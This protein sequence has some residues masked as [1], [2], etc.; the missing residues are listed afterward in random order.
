MSMWRKGIA[1]EC[2]YLGNPLI[3]RLIGNAGWLLADRIGRLGLGVV[4]LAW[5]AR[6]LG[7]ANFGLLNYAQA[8]VVLVT[9]VAQFGLAD[10]VVRDIV[11]HP[12]RRDAI[13]STALFIRLAMGA[14]SVGLSCLTVYLLDP[15]DHRSL[16]IT[17]ALSISLL[18]QA[19]EVLEYD[20]QA[21]NHV[22]PAVAARSAAFFI[23]N[24]IKIYGILS[25][26][27]LV[28][29]AVMITAEAAATAFFFGFANRE[30]RRL[31]SVRHVSRKEARYLAS[32][33]T[34]LF[35]RTA[36]I[37]FY[38]RLDQ[39]LITRMYGDAETGVYAAAVRLVEVWFFVPIAIMTAL[40]PTL[41]AA[42]VDDQDR[43]RRQLKTAMRILVYASMAFALVVT[44]LAGPIIS[45]LYG[46]NYEGAVDILRLY[47]WS[48][49][50]GTLGLAT[51]AWFVN[52]GLMGYAFRQAFIGLILN[53]VLNVTLIAAIGPL[54]GAIAY[55]ASQVITNYLLN[56]V[57]TPTNSVFRL[58]TEVLTFR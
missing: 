34:P 47:A 52:S 38:M 17:L 19:A 14:T 2:R 30:G 5:T 9:S 43:Y 51:N 10:V 18:F 49:V 15:G 3:R 27:G 20:L 16:V 35:F 54:G 57:F 11:R 46:A 36:A 42:F 45:F 40:V 8:I 24:A 1:T 32:Q 21:R 37:A 28:F 58:Q 44:L 29:F 26:A 13:I 33:A 7:P 55:L 12:D 22:V 6:Y 50:F 56:A 25:G 4:I 39:I 31:A 53:A 41:A 48:S 23:C